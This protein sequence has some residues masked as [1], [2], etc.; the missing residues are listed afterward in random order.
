MKFHF[1]SVMPG[2]IEEGL[3]FGV[4][5]SAFKKGICNYQI[6]NPRDFTKDL[7]Q[8]VDDRPFGGGDGMLMMAEPLDQALQSLETSGPVYYLSPQGKVFDDSMA[9]ELAGENELTFICGRY[10]GVDQRFLNKN[11]IKEVSIGDFVLSGGELASLVMVDA[12][13]RHK[14]GVLGHS[15][16]A[17]EDSFAKG[18]LELPYFTRPQE[19]QDKRIP[20]ILLSGDHKKIN[21]FKE[22]MSLVTTLLKRPDLLQEGDWDFKGT[23]EYLQEMSDEDCE[24]MGWGKKAAIEKLEEKLNG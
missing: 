10:G 14:P 6:T 16:S 17:N 24:A 2:L 15:A 4:I 13:V 8:T 5:G 7:H 23:L 9:R 11:Q 19:W 22:H 3:K 21:A 1:I 12:I 18:L 20:A